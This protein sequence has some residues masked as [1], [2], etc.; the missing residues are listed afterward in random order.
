MCDRCDAI[1]RELETLE[2]LR[3]T[4][5]DSVALA[6]IAEAVKDLQAERAALHPDDKDK[7]D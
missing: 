2:R 6:L 5:V 3:A 4:I 1:E 7:R